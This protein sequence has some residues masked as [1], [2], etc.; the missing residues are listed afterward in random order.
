MFERIR[1]A[2][3]LGDPLVEVA[4]SGDGSLFKETFRNSEIF[5]V[6][7]PVPQSLD[8]DLM[9]DEDLRELMESAAREMA[10]DG[11]VEPF[12]YGPESDRVLPV[13]SCE[14]AAEAF[15]EAYVKAAKRVIPLVQRER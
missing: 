6:S 7:R 4:R 3:S 11:P 5:V 9:S 2:F 12:T 8:P 10:K 15:V 13:F 1:R 14:A